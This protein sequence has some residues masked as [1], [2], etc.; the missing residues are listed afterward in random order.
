MFLILT[1][2]FQFTQLVESELVVV[3][4]NRGMS[5]VVMI[6]NVPPVCVHR[7]CN[8]DRVRYRFSCI[9]GV[10]KAHNPVFYVHC[11]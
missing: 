11:I 1:I 10:M 2:Y 9:V 4:W 8:V 5:P 3:G 6:Y 7:T